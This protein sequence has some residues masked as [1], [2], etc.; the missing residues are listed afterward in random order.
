LTP[1]AFHLMYV[2]VQL[3]HNA[4]TVSHTLKGYALLV[5]PLSV[6]RL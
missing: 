6:L 2:P 5:P 3:V 1:S 4:V